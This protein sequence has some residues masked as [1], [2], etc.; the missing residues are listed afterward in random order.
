MVNDCFVWGNIY[1]TK[2]KT[3]G[4]GW[5]LLMLWTVLPVLAGATNIATGFPFDFAID[6]PGY[7]VVRDPVANQIHFTRSANLE[8]DADSYLVTPDGMRFQGFSNSA[9]TKIG[10]LQL[11]SAGGPA[12]E[13]ISYEIQSNGCVVIDYVD[14]SSNIGCQIL[15]Q[16]FQNPSALARIWDNMFDCSAAAGLL[17]AQPVPPDISGTGALLSGYLEQLVPELQLSIYTGPSP[18]FSQGILAPTGIVTDLGVQGNGFFVLRRTNDNALF[19]TRA[20]G[21]YLDG[22]GYVVHYSGLRLQGYTNPALTSIG[23]VQIDPVGWPSR[24]NPALLAESFSIDRQG[25]ITETLNDGSI[26]VTGQVLLQNC[27]NPDLLIR[28]SFDLYPIITNTGLWSPLAPPSIENLQWIEEGELELSQFDTNLLAV[29]SNLNFFVQGALTETSLP[30][31]LSILGNGFFTVRDPL[32]N[33]LYATR[34]GAF[35]LD[36]LGHLVTANGLRVQGFTNSGL[37]QYGDITIDPAGAPDPSVTLSSYTIDSQGCIQVVLSDGSQFLRGQV[38]L[39]NYRNIQGLSVAGNGLYSNLT[40]AV[41]LFTN[42]L[43]VY[44]L[45]AT[46]QSGTLEEPSGLPAPLQLPPASGYR[47]FINDVGGG[48]AQVESSCDLRH[49]DVIGPVNPSELNTAEFFDPSPATQKF[50]RVVVQY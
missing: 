16:A 13:F 36:S 45:P 19:A 7:F 5:L 22:T 18:T 23:D 17:F 6:G 20:G 39:Q 44:I 29:R 43:S 3:A 38:V 8:V 46:M 50:Y 28:E 47:L 24:S 11:N 9:L 35:Q 12:P 10:D 31:N 48:L 15:L 33:I 27:S 49:W 37:M 26:Y 42:G 4:L 21:F 14:G 1:T 32:S 41:P 34:R 25:V 2:A 40:A 30:A